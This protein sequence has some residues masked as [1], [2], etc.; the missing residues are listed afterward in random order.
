MSLSFLGIVLALAL[1]LGTAS[2]SEA[3]DTKVRGRRDVYQL[4]EAPPIGIIPYVETTF[5][6][7]KRVTVSS[8]TSVIF[9]AAIIYVALTVI[10]S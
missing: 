5:D 9:L 7:A 10:W 1:G 2:L 8:V 6:K 4:L 3:I